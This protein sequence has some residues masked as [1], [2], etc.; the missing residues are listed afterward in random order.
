MNVRTENVQPADEAKSFY[1]LVAL[2]PAAAVLL[3]VMEM[4][5]WAEPLAL[6]FLFL[7]PFVF[8]VL[9]AK[10]R[11]GYVSSVLLG[12]LPAYGQTVSSVLFAST[13]S[14]LRFILRDV[15][16]GLLL[17]SG[18]VLPVV[19]IGFVIGAVW[20]YRG[21]LRDRMRWIGFRVG[22]GTVLTVILVAA[23][24]YQMITFLRLV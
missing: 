22:I 3:A 5:G 16:H 1:I 17:V 20:L 18:F 13:Q 8:S 23:A 11:G 9:A 21:D 6:I 4:Y 15:V 2:S 19:T 14:S 7:L 24:H 10:W 12:L